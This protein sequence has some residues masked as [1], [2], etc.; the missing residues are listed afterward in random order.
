MA[1][2]SVFLKQ[3]ESLDVSPRSF[4]VVPEMA[5]RKKESGR[6]EV[7]NRTIFKKGSEQGEQADK[8]QGFPSTGK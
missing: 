7:N 8:K 5:K 6:I 2:F 1:P 3:S 4:Y